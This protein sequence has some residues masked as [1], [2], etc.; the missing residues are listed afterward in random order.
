MVLRVI[1]PARPYILLHITH[2]NQAVD[3]LTKNRQKSHEN[4]AKA[5]KKYS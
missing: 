2:I 1:L 4:T 3:I 5:T